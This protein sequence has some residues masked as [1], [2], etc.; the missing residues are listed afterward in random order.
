M[1]FCKY[2]MLSIIL[3]LCF[4]GAL[5]AGVPGAWANE[6]APAPTLEDYPFELDLP[7][8]WTVV[9]SESTTDKLSLAIDTDGGRL[10]VWSEPGSRPLNEIRAQV[11]QLASVRGWQPIRIRRT[12][13]QRHRALAML[14]DVP[15]G[16]LRTRQL[17]YFFNA[18]A[19]R[20]VLQF[21]TKHSTFERRLYRQ[22]AAS[23]RVRPAA[24]L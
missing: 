5:V 7:A 12:R 8:H 2:M 19:Q 4:G 16:A 22:I 21:G 6:E 23:L 11:V 15:S 14:Y 20:Y 17:F 18:G 13:I 1:R 9:E 10:T 24:T 3:P